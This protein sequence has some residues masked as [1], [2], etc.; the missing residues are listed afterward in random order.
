M[1][2]LLAIMI[3]G[4]FMLGSGLVLAKDMECQC[5]CQGPP[6]KEMGQMQEDWEARR[7][8]RMAKE[9]NLTADQKAKIGAIM[10][11]T[12]EDMAA[13]RDASEKKVKAVLTPDQAK[14]LDEMKAEMRKRMDERK[15][16]GMEMREKHR[17]GD[18]PM[19]E[20]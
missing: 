4:I 3:V 15:G 16:K 5:K 10:D 19:K 6:N 13:V 8:D 2:K 18:G 9:L 12:K 20:Q 11:K 1:K 14:K 17:H 7:L